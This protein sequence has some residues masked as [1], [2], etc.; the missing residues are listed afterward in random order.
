MT[1][2]FV[3]M[4]DVLCS[5]TAAHSAALKS[6][7]NQKFPQSIPGFFQNLTP[8]PGAILAVNEL[9][10]LCDVFVL[11]APSTRNPHSY[12]E[13][14]LWIERHFDYDF[15]KRLI[16]SP[17]KDLLK[18][19]YL[20]D[21]RAN[22]KGQDLFEGQLILFGSEDFPDWSSVLIHLKRNGLT[23]C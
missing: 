5:Y 15:T 23:N 12:T 1:V 19:D 8:L 18:G 22:G 11:S 2:V 9:R 14:R 7:P 16:L 13:K 21:D 3:D 4:D 10:Q 20:I 6:D 17:H